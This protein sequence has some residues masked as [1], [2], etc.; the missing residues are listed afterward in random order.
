[1]ASWQGS[2]IFMKI[3]QI[4]C[5]YPP[6]KG[7]IATSARDFARV[8]SSGVQE[9]KTF[10]IDYGKMV[11]DEKVSYLK[12]IPRIGKGGFLPQLFFCLN[13]FDRVV[14]H[15]PFFGAAEIVWFL[16]KF[17]WKNKKKLFIHYHMDVEL[18]SLFLRALSF[19]ASLIFNSLFKCA[20]VITCASL[21]Y[22]KNG[23]LKAV[24]EKYPTK[25]IEIP[26]G[27]DTEKFKPKENLGSGEEFFNILFVGGLD[28]AH[29]FKG[30]D[31]LLAA[32]AKIAETHSRIKVSIVG[33]GDMKS[34]YESRARSLGIL[35]RVVFCGYVSDDDLPGKY[36]EADCLVLP[37]INKSEAFGI[38]VIE[39]LSS[40]LPVIASDL[41]GVRGVFDDGKE[42]FLV[43]PGDVDDLAD[44]IKEVIVNKEVREKMATAARVLA[45][46]KYSRL[47]IDEELLSIF[48]N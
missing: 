32:I 28:R 22:V 26:F 39:A 25:F 24:Y 6:Y 10:T 13:S 46:K 11:D 18:P 27:V 2:L 43:R 44:K 4:T 40:G 41:P 12:A 1:M 35:D 47:K 38:V 23:K 33:S 5:V 20:D 30:V 31:I 8:L 21:D 15:Y 19:P 9:F 3:A 17:F 36:K 29:Y 14:L 16:K 34:F 42:G 45:E 48:S 7:G 37:S